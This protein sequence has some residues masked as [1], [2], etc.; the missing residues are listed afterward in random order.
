VLGATD[1]VSFWK[2]ENPMERMTGMGGEK[3]IAGK[4]FLGKLRTVG[5][6]YRPVEQSENLT[7]MGD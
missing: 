6:R 1:R 3:N 7:S 5:K 2:N 4:I